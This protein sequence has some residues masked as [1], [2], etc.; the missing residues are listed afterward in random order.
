MH[1]LIFSKKVEIIL[2]SFAIVL[3]LLVDLIIISLKKYSYFN[4]TWTKNLQKVLN[5]L[6][7]VMPILIF[8]L[9][10]RKYITYD[11]MT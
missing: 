11:Y 3:F 1:L 8:M 10:R 9:S 4:Q 2:Y 5:L 7:Q 6:W